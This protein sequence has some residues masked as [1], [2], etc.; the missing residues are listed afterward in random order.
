V[1]VDDDAANVAAREHVV[2]GLVDVVELVLGGD[3]LV[4]E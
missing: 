1:V 3:C 2:V 4:Q